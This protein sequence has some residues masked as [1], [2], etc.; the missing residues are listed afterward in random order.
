MQYVDTSALLKRYVAEPDS[1]L[2]E[3]L[4]QEDPGWVAAA[5][6][7][8]E[9]RRNLARVFT[10][11]PGLLRRAREAFLD[12][13]ETVHVVALDSHVCEQAA[14]LA[15]T[16]G[17][18]TLDALHLAAAQRAGAPALRLVAFDLRLA[19]VARGLGWTVVGA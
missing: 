15:E 4:L 8:V 11:E 2:A 17:A 12:D 6:T 10:R 16:T 1:E 5:H 13:W 14:A 9:V 19:Q 3:R 7:A 18:R